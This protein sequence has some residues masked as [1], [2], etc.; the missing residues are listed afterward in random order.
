MLKRPVI[1]LI[2]QNIAGPLLSQ[3][4][5][6]S[7]EFQVPNVNPQSSKRSKNRKPEVQELDCSPVKG[8]VKRKPVTPLTTKPRVYSWSR[9]PRH[10]QYTIHS[11]G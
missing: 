8:E 7:V 5:D 4:Q 10:S 9:V 11:K 6:P 2:K 3:Q 1:K